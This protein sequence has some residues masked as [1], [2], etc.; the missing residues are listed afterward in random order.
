[1]HCRSPDKE[2]DSQRSL[3]K[4]FQA[5]AVLPANSRRAMDITNAI[6]YFGVKDMLPISTNGIGF[7][8]LLHVLEPR[9]T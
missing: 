2:D 9:Y 5:T 3:N 8:M 7:Q 1:M 4:I 6:G